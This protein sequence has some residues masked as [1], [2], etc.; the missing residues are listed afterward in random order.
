MSST[1][2]DLDHGFRVAELSSIRLAAQGR[3]VALAIF[4]L[5]TVSSFSGALLYNSLVYLS[6][7]GVLALAMLLSARV[8]I[9]KPWI[10]FVL[11]AL[12]VLILTEAVLTPNPFN[13]EPWPQAM[14]FRYD[15]FYYFFALIAVSVFSYSPALVVWVGCCIVLAWGIGVSILISRENTRLL[16][17]VVTSAINNQ[18]LLQSYL[19]PNVVV[20]SGRIKEMVT[21]LLV[22]VL[23]AV[24]VWRGRTTVADLITAERDRR[25]L[26][27]L[28]GRYVPQQIAD[29]IVQDRGVLRPE[30]RN[31][32][33]LFADIEHFTSIVEGMQPADA[34]A[35]LNA[36][37]TAATEIVGRYNGVVTQF[38]GDAILA[39]FNLPVDDPQHAV[40]AVQAA[41]ELLTE[42][43]SRTFSGQQLRARIGINTGPVVAGSV[44]GSG[45]MFYTVHGDAVNTAARLEQLNKHYDSRVLVSETTVRLANGTS[46]WRKVS[47]ETPRGRSQPVAIY[48][49]DQVVGEPL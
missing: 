19:D 1:A 14:V 10:K 16:S 46:G 41:K 25:M 8:S 31:A 44:G 45:R 5:Y 38:Q 9:E 29:A 42:T 11:V 43:Q 17:D 15:N 18:E 23:L 3:L 32:T 4:T 36:Y 30:E 21:A 24:V 49:L 7:F 12:E 22:A 20:I 37:F 48:T 28:F 47:E 2:V 34:L 26:S 13:T 6:G 33:V 35:M 40:N 27:D 39:T